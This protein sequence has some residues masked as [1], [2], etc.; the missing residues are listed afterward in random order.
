VRG[1][2]KTLSE[3][4]ASC[5]TARVL[6]R[7]RAVVVPTF[8]LPAHRPRLGWG[9]VH[10]VDAGECYASASRHYASNLTPTSHSELTC[11][12]WT[13]WDPAGA[14]H[15]AAASAPSSL[16]VKAGLAAPAPPLYT[17]VRP[18]SRASSNGVSAMGRPPTAPVL[19][20]RQLLAS[21]LVGQCVAHRSGQPPLAF[22]YWPLSCSGF[23]PRP[24]PLH[25]AHLVETVQ[26]EEALRTAS[27]WEFDAFRLADITQGSPLAV[28][29]F[30][31]FH[32]RDFIAK[33][34]LDVAALARYAHATI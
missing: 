15:Q 23:H 22:H 26:V 25:L 9:A 17:A 7:L 2:S 34:S 16:V 31:L 24:Q 12:A 3:R 19:C 20:A 30:Y 14:Q 11:S 29:G 6:A 13:L 21:F 10:P 5:C 27:E 33:F 28:L 4:A 18:P 32:E 1:P 8:S